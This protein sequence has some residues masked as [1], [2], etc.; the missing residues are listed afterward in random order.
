MQPDIISEPEDPRLLRK[1][2]EEEV[3]TGTVDGDV[4]PLSHRI[5]AD[6]CGFVT[7][8]DSRNVEYTTAPYRSYHGAA[9]PADGEAL[10]APPLPRR[11]R[12]L[13]ADS[14]QHLVARRE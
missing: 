10:P 8:P 7:E 5:A 6:L 2:L 12:Q 13:H 9:R 4:V 3:Y 14:R 11:H 1:G